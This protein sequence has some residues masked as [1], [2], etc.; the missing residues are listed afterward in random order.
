MAR[1]NG[2]GRITLSAVGASTALAD[3]FVMLP[4]CRQQLV[5]QHTALRRN[6]F[7]VA[8]RDNKQVAYVL[9]VDDSKVDRLMAGNFVETGSHETETAI[10]GRDALEK[11]SKR[12]PDLVLTDMVMD[13]MGGLELVTRVRKQYPGVPVILMTGYGTDDAA[14]RALQAGA[15]SYIPKDNLKD[16]LAGTIRT[17]LIASQ[18]AAQVRPHW[19]FLTE[20]ESQYVLGYETDGRRTLID[21]FEDE[22]TKMDFCDAADRIRVGTALAEALTNAVEHG[23]LELDSSLRESPDQ[24]YYDLGQERRAESPYNKR[25][26]FITKKV[27][28]SQITYVIRDEGPGFDHTDLPDP[29]DPENLTKLSGRGLLLIRT[30]MDDVVFNSSGNQITLVKQRSSNGDQDQ[31]TC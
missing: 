26:V 22:L 30:F 21:H 1:K 24:T 9:I 28:P 23:N 25:R 6:S 19:M 17:A 20:S 4:H 16:R 15:A 3:E 31:E 29:T 14:V 11:M 13:E 7:A 18:T 8:Q 2:G 10:N 5:R 12:L 27:T